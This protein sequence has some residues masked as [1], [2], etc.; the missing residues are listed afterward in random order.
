M[1]YARFAGLVLSLALLVTSLPGMAAD[2]FEIDA[3][4]SLTGPGSFLGKNE[5][6]AIALVE[7][8]VNKAG[9]IGGRPIKFVISDDQSSPQVAIQLTNNIIAKNPAIVLGSS[10]VAA[11][12]AMAAIMKNGPVLFCLSAGMHPE[13][14][15]YAFTYGI[16]TYDLIGVTIRYFRDRGWKRLAIITSTDASGQDGEKGIDQALAMPA[17]KDMTVVARE[18]YAVADVSVS[19]QMAHIKASAPQAVIAWGTGTPFGTVLHGAADVGLDVPM[20][21][22]ASN[23]TYAEMKQFGPFLPKVL[24]IAGLPC[25]ALASIPPGPLHKAVQEY[26]DAFMATGV[27]P[28]VAQAIGWDPALITVAA[29]SKL[30]LNATAAQIKDY[31]SN[32]HGWAGANGEYDFRDGSQRGLTSKNGIMVRW[33]PAKETW[34]SVSKF[35]GAPL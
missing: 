2:P 31:I 6:A 11:C 23:L 32:L 17:N 25:V 8:K 22:S 10:L 5:A 28:D 30:G 33:D 18:H 3:V 1:R 27:R 21:G 7:Q 13:K 19:A 16:S 24:D 12:N 26:V 34:V 15:S 20:S 4:L 29:Y 14:G 9:G 35:G